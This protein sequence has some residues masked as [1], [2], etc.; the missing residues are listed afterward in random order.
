MPETAEQAVAICEAGGIADT[1]A[2]TVRSVA[3]EK[4][5]RITGHELGPIPPR[6]DGDDERADSDVALPDWIDDD[7]IP[8]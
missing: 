2:I 3:G 5:D 7:E 4:Y 6:L 8:F 1:L